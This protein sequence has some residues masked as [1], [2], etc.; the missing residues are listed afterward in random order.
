MRE[1]FMK[2]FGYV[3]APKVLVA[4]KLKVRFMY[5]EKPDNDNDS[6]WRFFS[7]EE[8]QE[9]VDN[10]NNIAI[11]DI[12]TIL[13]FDGD[14]EKYLLLP[15]GSVFEREDSSQ[16]FVQSVNFNVSDFE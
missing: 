14:I 3:L 15:I 11:Y 8:D 2:K 9:Y 1:G 13:A 7:G 5:R 6:G 16:D 12:E 4:N 10:P